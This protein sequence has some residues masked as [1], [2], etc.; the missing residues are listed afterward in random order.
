MK[1]KHQS[2]SDFFSQ[3]QH[4]VKQRQDKKTDCENYQL[5]DPTRLDEELKGEYRDQL[6]EAKSWFSV[7]HIKQTQCMHT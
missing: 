7:T 1:T 3:K 5:K 6:G 2:K 4:R